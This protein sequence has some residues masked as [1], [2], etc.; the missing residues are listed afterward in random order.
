MYRKCTL[1]PKLDQNAEVEKILTV[2]DD[3]ETIRNEKKFILP[4][5]NPM[6]SKFFLPTNS[7]EQKLENSGQHRYEEIGQILTGQITKVKNQIFEF[8]AN[9]PVLT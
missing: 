9:L 4:A 3:N 7:D 5:G 6:F 1:K 8:D 2:K